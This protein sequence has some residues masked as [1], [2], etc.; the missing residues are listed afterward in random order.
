MATKATG[1]I[2]TVDGA[3]TV[4]KFLVNPNI[5]TGGTPSADT[6]WDASYGPENAVNRNN[7]NGPD[8]GL[9]W[10]SDASARP[11]WWKYDLGAGI[12]KAVQKLRMC[13][14]ADGNG[15]AV[16][17]FTVEGSNDDT[18]W[19]VVYTGLA[20]NFG[21]VN[22]SWEEYTFANNTQYRYYRVVFTSGYNQNTGNAVY[23][24]EMYEYNTFTPFKA[25]NVEV[26]VV[27]GGGKGGTNGGGAGG[28]GGLIHAAVHAVSAQAYAITVGN[29]GMASS[30][31]VGPNG[32]NSVFDDLVAIGG[33]GGGGGYSAGAG[34]AGGSGGGGEVFTNPGGAGTEGQGYAGAAAAGGWESGG[35]GGAGGA[36]GTDGV[37][38]AKGP[39]QTLSITGTS[40][41]YAEGGLG[42]EHNG[43]PYENTNGSPNT[44]N[45]G[46]GSGSEYHQGGFGGSGVVIIRYLTSAQEAGRAWSP[47]ITSFND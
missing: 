25:G 2:I 28:A 4:H 35:G 42:N 36:G 17:D 24:F 44:G 37:G 30:A 1:G 5:L 16:K 26:L 9:M 18:N 33:G 21:T 38:R 11:H 19:N 10:S 15:Q 32:E 20:T 23:K 7:S 41:V 43:E 31:D 45:G 39:G 12:T 47:M 14:Y 13:I 8:A 22:Q 34:A 6:V 29:G 3:Y 40:S 27:A 46:S